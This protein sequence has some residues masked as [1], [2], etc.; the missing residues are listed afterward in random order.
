MAANRLVASK[1]PHK[2]RQSGASLRPSGSGR[3]REKIGR[4][5]AAPNSCNH[6]Q[7]ARARVQTR[8]SHKQARAASRA[9]SAGRLMSNEREFF[10]SLSLSLSLRLNLNAPIWPLADVNIGAPFAPISRNKSAWLDWRAPNYHQLAAVA[11]FLPRTR[12]A[13]ISPQAARRAAILICLKR[14]GPT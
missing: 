11:P 4:Q 9:R 8:P 5:S 12:V 13:Q 14:S 1:A 7:F 3:P 10:L 6:Q 2:R